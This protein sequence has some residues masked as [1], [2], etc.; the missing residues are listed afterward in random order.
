MKENKVNDTIYGGAGN[1][2]I[3]GGDG[4]DIIYAGPG[5]DYIYGG[6]GADIIDGGNGT[7]TLAFKG[8]GSL[9]I[10]VTV[11]LIIGI[12]KGGDAEGDSYKSIENVY[13]TDSQRLF[14][15]I[16]Y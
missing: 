8:D 4:D 1:D 12:G 10:G 16:R 5:D 6:N 9:R 7:D 13:G 11:D 15:R 3:F 14:D 2:I